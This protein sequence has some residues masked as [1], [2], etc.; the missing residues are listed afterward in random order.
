MPLKLIAVSL[1]LVVLTGCA[2]LADLAGFTSEVESKRDTITARID[3]LAAQ[4]DALPQ[5]DPRRN[6]IDASI[7]LL[8]SNQRTLDQALTQLDQIAASAES[9]DPISN[10]VGAVAPWLPEPVRTPALLVGGLAAALV[11]GTQ[12]KKSAASIARSIEHAAQQDPQ[13]KERLEANKPLLEA[14][15]TRTAKRIAKEATSAE[16]LVKLPL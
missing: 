3:E 12:L 5:A 10:V 13:L 4:R 11:R 1:V 8:T 14:E 6:Q 16:K 15:Q 9:P 7:A 2:S